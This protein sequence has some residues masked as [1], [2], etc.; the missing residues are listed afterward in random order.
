[1][2]DLVGVPRAEALDRATALGLTL[3]FRATPFSS[4]VAKD[5]IAAQ[6]PTA[7]LLVAPGATIVVDI[8]A[9]SDSFALPDVVGKDL[10]AAR[11]ELRSRGLTVTFTTAVSD[12]DSGTV[13]ASMPAA[14]AAVATGDIVRLTL[15]TSV[16]AIGA[17]DLTGVAFVLDPAPPSPGDATD[18]SMDVALRVSALVSA[19]GGTV[20][21][22]RASGV[23][24]PAPTPAE[25]TRVAKET[26]A[27]ALVGLTVVPSSL[28]GMVLLTMPGT[29]GSD[30]TRALS[31][32]LADAVFASLRVDM[33]TIATL[34]ASDDA[35]LAGSGL[36]GVRVRLGSYASDKDAKSFA[37]QRWLELVAND[38]Y[39]ALAQLYGR[40]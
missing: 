36:P 15:A 37:D 30:Q 39:R 24:S 21:M 22:T 27:T 5:A 10:E 1:M 28:E 20:T 6:E 34:T 2:P 9:G 25:R 13:I 3:Q 19:A 31:G 23:T 18:V 26:S 32:P 7:G 35:V 4:T 29:A 38:I 14:G 12:A 33:S 40:Q 8:S 11:A 16:G 17:S